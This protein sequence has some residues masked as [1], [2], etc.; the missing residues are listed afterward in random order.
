MA[1][2]YQRAVTL[3]DMPFIMDELT[4]GAKTGNFSKEF[5]DP[6]KGKVLEVQLRD[7]IRRGESGEYTGHYL[8]ILIREVDKKQIGFIW[9][10]VA[11]GPID[12][13]VLEIR[14]VNINSEFRGKGFAKLILDEWLTAYPQHPFQATCFSDSSQMADMLHRRGFK[15]LSTSPTGKQSLFREANAIT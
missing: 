9:L 15:T 3:K 8:Y 7:V 5:L 12:Q 13:P 6:R 2:Y 1:D 11:R 10:M 4:K 14:A